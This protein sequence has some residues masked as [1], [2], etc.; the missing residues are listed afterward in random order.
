MFVLTLY[1]S[2][3]SGKTSTLF[4]NTGKGQR[5]IP[6]TSF[7]TVQFLRIKMKGMS[8]ACTGMEMEGG[9]GHIAALVWGTGNRKICRLYLKDVDLMAECKRCGRDSEDQRTTT[10]IL[11]SV[12]YHDDVSF[13]QLPYPENAEDRCPV[14][15]VIPGGIHHEGCYM[16]RCPRC[17]NRLVSC[18]CAKK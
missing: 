6:N 15:H 9:D 16:E 7:L 2:R 13:R 10:C 12:E 8:S 3:H 1:S 4:R 18:G 11:H 14:C 17:E 5:I